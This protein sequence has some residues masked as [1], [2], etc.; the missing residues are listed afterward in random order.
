MCQ[1]LFWVTRDV[2]CYRELGCV[3][4]SEI[5]KQKNKNLKKSDFI[6]MS[7]RIEASFYIVQ[8]VISIF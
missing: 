2:I 8:S 4:V 6:L 3:F 5:E 1:A 7:F